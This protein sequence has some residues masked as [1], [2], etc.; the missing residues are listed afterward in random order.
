MEMNEILALVQGSENISVEF[1]KST[2]DIT[3]DV[4]ETVGSFSNREGGH[5]FLG[6]KD[7]GTVL[8][9]DPNEIGRIQSEFVTTINSSKCY[10]PLFL[11]I[12]TTVIEGK[13]VLHIYV[14]VCAQVCRINGR[15]YDRNEDSDIDITNN[16]DAVYQAYARKQG[17][18]FVNKVTC[19]SMDALRPD[20]IKRA[21]KL[22]RMRRNDHPWLTMSDEEILRSEGLILTDPDRQKEGVTLAGIL[23]FGTDQTIMA[24]LPQHK[25][26]AIFRVE[27]LDRYDD[28]DVIITNLFDSYD[29]L[30]AFGAK[31]LSDPFVLEGIQS[32]SA[33]DKILREI[34][35]NLLAHQDFSSG[36]VAKFVI[37]RGCMST[38]NA[39]QAHGIGTLNLQTF[40]PFAKNP[41]ISRVFR[42]AGLA[43]ELGSGM[44]NT[45]KYTRL[46]SGHEPQFIEGANVFR[47]II[48]LAAVSTGRVGPQVAA[49]H[50]ANPQVSLQVNPQ[51]SEKV[52]SYC[53][54]PRS[55]AEITA[56]CSYKDRRSFTIHYLK[57]TY[58]ALGSVTVNLLPSSGLL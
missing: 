54:L 11:Q 16:S 28:R 23:L 8:G 49:N 33:R 37:E 30:M 58:S 40:A 4:Y 21:R 44:R 27:N 48:P 10:P 6:I 15:I 2:K 24:V 35:S 13:Q 43:D 39:N 42:D 25:T 9:V 52:L 51:V 5:I 47:T 38:E 32:I 3:K 1:K 18:Y 12:E 50:Q 36:Y 57:M 29:R 53:V 17:M 26:D 31:H 56:H 45:Y 55:K 34:F 20:L 41:P 46:Y 22:S 7:D 14:P 19:F